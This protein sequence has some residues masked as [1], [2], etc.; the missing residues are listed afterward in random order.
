MAD[1]AIC[2]GPLL[3]KMSYLNIKDILSATVLTG[4]EAIHPGLGFYLKTVN[5]LACVKN[6]I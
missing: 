4:A 6:A 2:I 1:E 5:L 3:P